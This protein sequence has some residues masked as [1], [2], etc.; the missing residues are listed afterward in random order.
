MLRKS[1]ISLKVVDSRED[2]CEELAALY[3]NVTVICGDETDH[4]LLLEEGLENADAVLAMTESDEE[5]IL[6]AISA[7]KFSH[8]KNIAR[9][10]KPEYNDIINHLDIDT[11]IYP[12]SITSDMIV[13]YV[14][15]LQNTLGSN[16]ETMYTF[17]KGKVEATEFIIGAGSPIVDIPL[18]E[19][20]EKLKENVLVAA[21]L[22]NGAVIIPHGQDMIK[23]GDAVVIVSKILG[24]NDISGIIR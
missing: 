9:I 18:S 21:I 2:R 16:V 3:E 4:D 24:L 22:R 12:K 23:V 5:N 6:L 8:G 7:K 15:A 17:I 10:N 13:R 1:G 11:A 19:L 14:R 20:R